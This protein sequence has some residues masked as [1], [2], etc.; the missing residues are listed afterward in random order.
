MNIQKR[1]KFLIG[2]LILFLIIIGSFILNKE[3]VLWN[4]TEVILETVPIDPRDILRGDYVILKYKIGE[5]EKIKNILE[6]KNFS[7]GDKVFVN[8]KQKP[9]QRVEV[10]DVFKE[11]NKAG[12]LFIKGIYFEDW[13]GKKIKFP[14]IEQY[15]V[16]EGKG[17]EVERMRGKN[18]EALIILTKD[19]EAVLKN[20]LKDGEPIDFS[21]IKAEKNIRF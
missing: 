5:G 21:K 11:K 16:P 7:Y 10:V 3:R 14:E 18:L 12:N 4:G 9:D 20:L 2:F 17:W 6:N 1:D 15:F 13:N 19:G 8:L